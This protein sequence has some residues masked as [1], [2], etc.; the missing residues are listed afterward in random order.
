MSLIRE[1]SQEDIAQV[2]AIEC[3]NFSQP[4]TR[5]ALLGE[6][7]S[8]RSHYLIALEAEEV[9]GYIGFWKIFDEGHITNVAVKK[10]RHNQGIG[11]QLVE[12][13]IALG[14]G[15]GVDRY[16]LEVRVGNQEAIHLYTKY[17]F[18]E[19]GIRKGFYEL[20]KEDAMIMW[21]EPN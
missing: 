6:I 16:T 21:R 1:L 4:W 2:Y 8:E 18:V 11:S 14:Y 5:E 17:G 20:P 3:E 13:M 9:V 19:A 15:L 12:G 7:A 10:S